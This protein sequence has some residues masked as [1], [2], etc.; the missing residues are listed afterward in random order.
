[1]NAYLIDNLHIGI[2]MCSDIEKRTLFAAV[3]EKSIAIEA[4]RDR[5]G[6]LSFKESK[7][8]AQD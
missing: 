2:K 7:E 3:C 1:M 5:L 8:V 4:L 6:L